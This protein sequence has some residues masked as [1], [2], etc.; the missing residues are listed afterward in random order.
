[1]SGSVVATAVA[2]VASA[3]PAQ[4]E[5]VAPA[6]AYALF[7]VFCVYGTAPG[8]HSEPLHVLVTYTEVSFTV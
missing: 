5:N 2:Q 8:G 6:G 4:V 1:M 3:P 7:C